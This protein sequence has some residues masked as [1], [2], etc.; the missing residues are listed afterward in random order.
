MVCVCVWVGVCEGEY[1]S[2]LISKTCTL[3][4]EHDLCERF[5]KHPTFTCMC[6]K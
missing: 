5:K 6:V 2:E 1:M 4:D 3:H